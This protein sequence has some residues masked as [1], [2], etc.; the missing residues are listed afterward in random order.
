MGL[1]LFTCLNRKYL[2]SR[3]KLTTFYTSKECKLSS[4][5]KF[6]DLSTK[7]ASF[8]TNS[9]ILPLTR[10]Q[11]TLMG[12]KNSEMKLKQAVTLIFLPS[13]RRDRLRLE[14]GSDWRQAQ[15]GDRLRVE[16]GSEWR[17][18]QSGDRLRVETGSEWRQDQSG[19]RIRVE[20]GSDWRQDQ[21]GDRLR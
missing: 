8:F 20:T 21:T 17:Q 9:T 7:L 13:S 19:D 18:A 4:S 15:T 12:T 16:T 10:I 1:P 14:T 6:S 3:R 11:S 5:I 2:Q